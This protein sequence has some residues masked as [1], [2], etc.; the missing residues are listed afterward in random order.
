SGKIVETDRSG[1]IL[2]TL[3]IP[4]EPNDPGVTSGNLSVVEQ[5]H[6]GITMDRNGFLYTVAENGGGDSDHPQIWIYSSSDV[7][8]AA[9]TAVALTNEVTSLP[10]DTSTTARVKVADISVTDD[11]QGTNNFSVTG[12]DAAYFEAD[13]TGL[14]IKAGTVLDFATKSSYN[15]TV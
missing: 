8:N 4:A 5:S 10:D 11:G 9:P 14:Y 12:P 1:N 3:V 2:S 15:V 6:E 13:N 7:P